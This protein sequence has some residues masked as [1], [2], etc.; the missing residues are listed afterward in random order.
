MSAPSV[1][2]IYDSS[3]A[4][5]LTAPNF[6]LRYFLRTSGNE[7]VQAV[8]QRA[9]GIALNVKAETVLVGWI[10]VNNWFCVLR[11]QGLVGVRKD[12]V[13]HLGLRSS[14]L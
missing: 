6:S 3:S 7:T 9:V 14:G 10:P 12:S 2:Q 5:Q 1:N 11:L 8:G 4:V 13:C